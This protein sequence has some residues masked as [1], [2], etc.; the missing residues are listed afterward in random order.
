[1]ISKTKS[2]IGANRFYFLLWGWVAFIGIMGQ[3]VLKVV[4]GYAQ[5]YIVWLIVLPAVV[6]SII[7]SARDGRRQQ[8]RT[9][10][11]ENMGYLW[12]GMGISFFVL[13]FIITN[14]RVP[15]TGWLVSYPFY[16]L[17]YGLGTFVS[18]KFLQFPPLVI[19]GIINWVLAC[20][21]VFFP[22][23]YQMLFAATAIVVSYLIPGYLIKN[24]NH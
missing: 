7:R 23:D 21:A 20:V 11:G 24:V 17:L 2:S 12:T 18:G 3:F 8:V 4:F 19:G 14:M 22:F 5:H 10:V 1:M 16:I 13:G 15:Q 6:A 9:Y